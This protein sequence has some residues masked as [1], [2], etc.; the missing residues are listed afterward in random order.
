M[1]LPFNNYVCGK[2][3]KIN[4][5]YHV[6]H[7]EFP[8]YIV[9]DVH[10][11]A[12]APQWW[13]S[14]RVYWSNKLKNRQKFTNK[15]IDLSL[16]P[17]FIHSLVLFWTLIVTTL[18]GC[19]TMMAMIMMLAAKRF[20]L[21]DSM[22]FKSLCVNLRARN[23]LVLFLY[24]LHFNPFIAALF[25]RCALQWYEIIFGGSPPP[26]R[27][28]NPHHA[29]RKMKIIVFH[30]HRFSFGASSTH[31]HYNR[32]MNILASL[33][34]TSRLQIEWTSRVLAS[35]STLSSGWDDTRFL[36]ER[37]VTTLSSSWNRKKS[38]NDLITANMS[39]LMM[40]GLD[41]ATGKQERKVWR[42]SRA[43]TCEWNWKRM[44]MWSRKEIEHSGGID[45]RRMWLS[46]QDTSEATRGNQSA[47]TFTA[48]SQDDDDDDDGRG[49][50]ESETVKKKWENYS[51]CDS[52]NSYIT[53]WTDN[54]EWQLWKIL[55]NE[56]N[57]Q[58]Q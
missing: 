2:C 57:I 52:R 10:S 15:P 25:D 11:S 42:L 35:S 43:R 40:V 6:M 46:H 19:A 58:S 41:G 7:R 21:F 31:S 51:E 44:W 22:L 53:N 38:S 47:L 8:Q 9:V 23:S 37:C 34:V 27:V 49:E 45:H 55:T 3:D 48:T 54:H 18:N 28:Y 56:S 20:I 26:S 36:R 14:T 29:T 17:L 16:H 33:S 32:L 1:S 12:S 39:S 50:K 4:Q 13:S 24:N 5:T 30:S